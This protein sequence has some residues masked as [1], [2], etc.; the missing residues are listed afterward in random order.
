MSFVY[1]VLLTGHRRFSIKW[2]NQITRQKIWL[3]TNK[4]LIP[5]F[6]NK[7]ILQA[8]L[9]NNIKRP[10]TDNTTSTHLQ[11]THLQK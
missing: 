3:C 4:Y 7:Q 10:I 11:T 5:P 1:E 6:S 2:E 8:Y 9:H